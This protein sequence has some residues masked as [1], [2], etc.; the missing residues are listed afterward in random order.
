MKIINEYIHKPGTYPFKKWL[1]S[2]NTVLQKNIHSMVNIFIILY[3]M[4]KW[5]MSTGN[6]TV[7]MILG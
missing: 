2:T 1:K 3:L 5:K 4:C 6:R 7:Q